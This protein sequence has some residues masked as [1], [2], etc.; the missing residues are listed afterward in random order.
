MHVFDP[1]A[2]VYPIDPARTDLPREFRDNVRGPHSVELKR[3]LHRM[4]S[5]AVENKWVLYV[6]EPGKR[7]MLAQ[8]PPERDAQL[9]LHEDHVF[10]SRDEAEWEVFKRRWHDITG[11]VVQ[12]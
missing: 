10:E 4:R 3:V 9:V 5:G 1:H 6:L 2:A 7:W 12:D 11:E 8:L